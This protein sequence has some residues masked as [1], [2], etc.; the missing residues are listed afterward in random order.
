MSSRKFAIS[1]VIVAA[2]LA[3]WLISFTQ[4]E[5]T[6]KNEAVATTKELSLTDQI[7]ALEA[8]G[9]LPKLDQSADLKGPDQNLNGVRDDIEAWIETQPMT[10][11][12]KRAATQDAAV[13]QKTLLVDLNDKAALKALSEEGMLSLSCLHDAYLPNFEAGTKMS[14][15]IEAMIANT[16]ERS[17]RYMQY[18]SA[19][20]GSSTR[21][22]TNYTCP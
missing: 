13:L 8:S 1:F 18:N 7:K 2:A 12:Q 14:R 3:I 10:D 6:T 4:A 15:K 9:K 16:R 11:V 21:A 19:M 5:T 22:P 20:S 17:L